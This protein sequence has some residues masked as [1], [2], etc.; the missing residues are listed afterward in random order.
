MPYTITR[1]YFNGGPPGSHVQAE[2]LTLEEAR[3]WCQDTETSSSTATGE[4]ALAHAAKWGPW[5]DGYREVRDDEPEEADYEVWLT[6][7]KLVI[8]APLGTAFAEING[9]AAIAGW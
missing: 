2:G 3:D 8:E 5:F 7:E 9:L 4:E 6:G 1:W